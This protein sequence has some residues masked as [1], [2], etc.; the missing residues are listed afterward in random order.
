MDYETRKNLEVMGGV[1]ISLAWMGLFG[2]IVLVIYGRAFNTLIPLFIFGVLMLS[3]GLGIR[4][5]L[6]RNVENHLRK[7]FPQLVTIDNFIE[8]SVNG[9]NAESL[10]D[11]CDF[12][13][14]CYDHL[15]RSY[16]DRG[17][18]P[19]QFTKIL[20]Q[21]LSSYCPI[22]HKKMTGKELEELLIPGKHDV[23]K[24]MNLNIRKAFALRFTQGKCLGCESKKIVLSWK[25]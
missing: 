20:E 23:L 24:G 10:L 8:C 14:L 7:L 2:G 11:I 1:F 16:K 25:N 12:K 9:K 13:T 4:I 17:L 3:A 21:N 6:N 15:Q 18:S 19:E 22:C 5:Y